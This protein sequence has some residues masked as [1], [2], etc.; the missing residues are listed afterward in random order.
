MGGH[1]LV[2]EEFKDIEIAYIRRTGKY[3]AENKQL[4]EKL[5]DYLKSNDLFKD[6][7]AILGIALDNPL[8]TPENELRYDVGMVINGKD[9]HCDL[10]IRNIDSGRYAIFEVPHTENDVAN[11]WENIDTLTSGLLV[12]YTKPI[13]ERYAFSKIS[14]HLCEF[15]IPLK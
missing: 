14:L 3:G 1:N 12:D 10:P 15:C 4:M 7:T 2:I 11:F 6:D 8:S 9:I 5:K 13:I